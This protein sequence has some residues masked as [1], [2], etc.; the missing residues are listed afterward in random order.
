MET[1]DEEY[2]AQLCNDLRI[3]EGSKTYDDWY[4]PSIREL[5][6]M[7]IHRTTINTA[8]MANDG[9]GFAGVNYWSSTQCTGDQAFTLNFGNGLQRYYNKGFKYKVR[10]IRVF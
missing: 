1:G 9:S 7:Y 6:Q 8:A 2:A 4:L 3:N 10:A 5:N